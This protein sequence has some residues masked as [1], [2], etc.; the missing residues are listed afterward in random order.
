MKILLGAI[1]THPVLFGLASLALTIWGLY[2]LEQK[3]GPIRPLAWVAVVVGL[4]VLALCCGV[5]LLAG[6]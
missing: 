3:Q 2:V 5:F 4:P 6:I 1:L